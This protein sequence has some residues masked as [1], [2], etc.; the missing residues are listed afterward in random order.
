MV[1]RGA[2]ADLRQAV[3]L[4]L[5]LPL[6]GCDVVLV[7]EGGARELVAQAGT[8]AASRTDDMT[9]LMEALLAE[10]SVEI[11]ARLDAGEAPTLASRLRPQ[12]RTAGADEIEARC[13]RADHWLV[14]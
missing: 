11:L 12:V 4:A 2:G 8:T 9:A 1:A 10:D 14:V 7:L 3:A 13:R 5:A 6:G